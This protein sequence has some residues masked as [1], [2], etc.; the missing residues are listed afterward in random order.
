LESGLNYSCV[1]W[2]FYGSWTSSRNNIERKAQKKRGG[3]KMKEKPAGGEDIVSIEKEKMLTN[4]R[5]ARNASTHGV[6]LR[7]EIGSEG[8]TRMTK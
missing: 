3:K 8:R 5:I 6:T 2:D 7:W 4:V 1:D